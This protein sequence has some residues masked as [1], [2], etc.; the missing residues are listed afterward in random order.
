MSRCF[1]F[2][3]NL[4]FGRWQRYRVV[5]ISCH[6]QNTSWSPSTRFGKALV[7]FSFKDLRLR[8]D[9]HATSRPQPDGRDSPKQKTPDTT[10]W[11]SSQDRSASHKSVQVPSFRDFSVL[12]AELKGHILRFTLF[13]DHNVDLFRK[14]AD[15]NACALLLVNHETWR[16][17]SKIYCGENR[18]TT[19][20]YNLMCPFDKAPVY[21]PAPNITRWIR[22]LD[23]HL[24]SWV[25][26]IHVRYGATADSRML[27]Q[28]L[29]P[30]LEEKKGTW[31]AEDFPQLKELWIVVND[32]YC[33][34]RREWWK[35]FWKRLPEY[36]A[37]DLR[38][39]RVEVVIQRRP[40]Y[41]CHYEERGTEGFF[42][43][44]FVRDV[45]MGMVRTR[46]C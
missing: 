25:T 21:T 12:P 22:K 28:W 41:T 27:E 2:L 15:K 17:A 44:G 20:G 43:A 4:S 14:D 33:L 45:L 13:I 31:R 1:F 34:G 16:L 3:S 18:I 30:S 42:R 7:I 10:P 6:F 8:I 36:T 37:I 26:A 38:P 9:L 39:E 32:M 46:G 23:I 5:P 29:H 40:D 11:L 24:K 19:Q 35:K